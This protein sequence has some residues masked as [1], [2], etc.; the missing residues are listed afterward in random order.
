MKNEIYLRFENGI[1]KGTAQ[2]KGEGIKYKRRPDGS[3]YG[4]IQHFQKRAVKLARAEYTSQ[5]KPYFP[6]K[7]SDKPIKL[8]IIF[9]HSIKAPR[10]IWGKYKTTRPDLDNTA[11]ELIDVMSADKKTKKGGFWLDDAQIVD[12]RLIK[13]YSEQATIYIRIEEVEA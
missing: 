5:L 12:L 10:S 4:Y 11:K 2:Q 13:Y 3:I 7:P 1:P 6:K 8:T 9:Y